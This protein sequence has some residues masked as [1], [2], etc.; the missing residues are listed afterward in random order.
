MTPKEPKPLIIDPHAITYIGFDQVYI[1]Y[2]GGATYVLCKDAK[3][4][5]AIVRRIRE[6]LR[7]HDTPAN[8]TS[9][10]MMLHT[11]GIVHN[12]S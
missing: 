2:L 9:V 5:A 11:L 8:A 10:R 1:P 4:S 6:H 3:A 7:E 12:P